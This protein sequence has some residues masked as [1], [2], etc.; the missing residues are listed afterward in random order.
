MRRLMPLL[1]V[2]CL[3]FAPAPVPRPPTK[4]DG[5]AFLTKLQGEWM[6]VSLEHFE[7]GEKI[8]SRPRSRVRVKGRQWTDL[9]PGVVVKWTTVAPDGE[10]TL[11]A[12]NTPV[13]LEV[14][15]QGMPTMRGIV[16][17]EKDLLTFC[18]VTN[19]D[20]PMPVSFDKSRDGQVLLNLESRSGSTIINE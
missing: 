16:R 2:L 17:L 19:P 3:G 20:S 4:V 9:I 7:G 10:L 13:R 15:R 18:Y 1:I 6:V 8:V 11:D 5:K 14:A 12:G